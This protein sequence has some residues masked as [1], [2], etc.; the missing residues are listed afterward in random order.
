MRTLVWS[1]AHASCMG[2]LHVVRE[3]VPKERAVFASPGKEYIYAY[4][5]NLDYSCNAKV[6]W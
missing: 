5:I 3:V 4:I 1:S 6:G 2:V